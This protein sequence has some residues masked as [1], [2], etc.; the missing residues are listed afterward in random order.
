LQRISNGIKEYEAVHSSVSK[1]LG[2]TYTP[3]PPDLIDAFS[4]DPAVVT[5]A[6][7]HRKGWQA[8]ED[9]HKNIVRQRNTVQAYLQ[10]ARDAV[11]APPES[12][13]DSPLGSLQQSLDALERRRAD[14]SNKVQE[15]SETLARV[16][17]LH[18]SVKTEYNETMA[19]TSSVY[20]EVRLTNKVLLSLDLY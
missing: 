5:G 15:V 1:T 4:H 14:V 3:L 18:A 20:P 9:I 12:V 2:L 16:K 11:F 10:R 6:T 7:R 17:T 13:L 8:V 19:H